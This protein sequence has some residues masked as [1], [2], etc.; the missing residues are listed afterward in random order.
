MTTVPWEVRQ[1]RGDQRP[2]LDNRR[3]H[4]T[5]WLVLVVVIVVAAVASY[6]AEHH[7]PAP[8]CP[9]PPQACGAPPAQ[10]NAAPPLHLGTVW[11]SSELG[12]TVEYSPGAWTRSDEDGRGLRLDLS[13]AATSAMGFSGGGAFIVVRGQPS[14]ETSPDQI[15]AS[16]VNLVRQSVADLE[17]DPRAARQILGPEIGYR[18]GIGSVYR[19]TTDGAAGG[20]VPVDVS[21]MAATDG[22]VTTL[23]V[24]VVTDPGLSS[25]GAGTRPG[26]P[27]GG[28]LESA[29]RSLADSVANAV[30]WPA[31]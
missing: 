12:Y 5:L 1:P 25:G 17:A 26:T 13:D 6:A 20:A 28:D 21:M 7:A 18:R 11:Q 9:Q 2:S 31:S 24:L 23:F 4:R 15:V 30:T 3:F 10:P 16:E 22:R 29:V 27:G 14:S 19:G 8:R